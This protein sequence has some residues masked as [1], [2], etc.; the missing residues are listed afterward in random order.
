[1]LLALA[2][3]ASTPDVTQA[4]QSWQGASYEEVVLLWGAPARSTTL[5]EGR[6]AHTWVSERTTSRGTFYPSVGIFGGS[7]NVGVGVG[8][9]TSVPFGSERNA[10]ERTLVFDQ[11][12][13]VEQNWTGPDAFCETFYRP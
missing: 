5:S 6:Q 2:G 3:C 9:G 8:V 11:G 7:G 4:K 12:R 10:C 13:V 1:M